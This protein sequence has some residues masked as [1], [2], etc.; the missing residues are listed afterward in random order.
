MELFF[1]Q[2]SLKVFG[3]TRALLK[4]G[5]R[6]QA[7]EK[8]GVPASQLTQRRRDAKVSHIIYMVD[9][10]SLV[11]TGIPYS[12]GIN[13]PSKGKHMKSAVQS[14]VWDGVTWLWP[15]LLLSR[16]YGISTDIYSRHFKLFHLSLACPLKGFRF[17][18]F[19]PPYIP[20]STFIIN[21]HLYIIASSIRRRY[22]IKTKNHFFSSNRSIGR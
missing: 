9:L 2:S 20:S 11:N 5:C 12:Y 18:Y 13:V 16:V 4:S 14:V 1:S 10:E 22:G 7:N 19:V 15:T 17:I 21:M 8:Y 3:T 6:P